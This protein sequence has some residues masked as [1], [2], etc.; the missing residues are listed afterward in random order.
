MPLCRRT[1]NIGC[2][3]KPHKMTLV[4]AIPLAWHVCTGRS[5]RGSYQW[6]GHIMWK[7][8]LSASG[9]GKGSWIRQSWGLWVHYTALNPIACPQWPTLGYISHPWSWKEQEL[10]ALEAQM[11]LLKELATWQPQQLVTNGKF[12][13]RLC[14]FK[15]KLEMGSIMV[16]FLFLW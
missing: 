1:S 2:W 8:V 3:E 4:S 6:P 9:A 10:R 15:D 7:G 5:E 13:A 11:L 12:T 16:S 14:G